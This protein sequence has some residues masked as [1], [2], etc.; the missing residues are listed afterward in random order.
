V[1]LNSA[2]KP[3]GWDNGQADS[4]GVITTTQSL[5]WAFGAGSMNLDT[6]YD[7]YLTG[8]TDVAGTG[9]GTVD[10]TGWDLGSL[11]LSGSNDYVLNGTMEVGDVITATLAWYR[12][13]TVNVGAGTVN[14]VGFADMDLEI[15]DSTFTTKY[16]SS[17]S[18]YN[19][20]EHLF[21]TVGAAGAYGIRVL[22]SDQIFGAST[23]ESYGLAWSATGDS[24]SSAPEPGQALMLVTLLAAAAPLASFRPRRR[25]A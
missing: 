5:D 21:Y 11:N 15:W 12:N 14:D 17:E 6:A 25:A 3:T 7:Q 24:G 23:A 1:L 2:D 4:G 19:S 18:D 22:Y 16:A 8:T 20:V 13:R 10:Q 9:G